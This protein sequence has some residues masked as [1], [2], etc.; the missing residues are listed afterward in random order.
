MTYLST[1][2]ISNPHGYT[3]CYCL[4]P[5]DFE[6]PGAGAGERLETCTSAG[7]RC[8]TASSA[9]RNAGRWP[10]KMDV[11]NGKFGRFMVNIW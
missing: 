5:H 10:D 9:G 11:L 2:H 3:I 6:A 8:R 4:S 7:G 1:C